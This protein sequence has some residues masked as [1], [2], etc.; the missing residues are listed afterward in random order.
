MDSSLGALETK[1]NLSTAPSLY[2][3]GHV[4][5]HVVHFTPEEKDVRFASVFAEWG[6]RIVPYLRRSDRGPRALRAA[7]GF[8]RVLCAM[9]TERVQLVRARLPYLGGLFGCLAGWLLGVPCVV[10]LG[11]DNRL[12]HDLS[13][14]YPFRNRPLS[15][16]I[17]VIV[18]RMAHTV[19]VPNSFTRDYVLGLIGA[20]AAARIRVIPWRIERTRSR[21]A[22]APPWLEP[23]I[24]IVL[25]VGFL[26][27]YKHT[28]VLYGVVERL[29][30]SDGVRAQFVFCGDGPL[31][32]LGE[33]TFTER[34]NVLFPGW[35]PRE[36]VETLLR[37]STLVL[38]P[39]S[40]FV[41]L[42]AASLG[43]AV[44]ASRLEWH[45]ELVRDGE[46]G[47]LVEAR[48]AAAW[49]DRIRRL[50]EDAPLRARLGEAL[51]LRFEADYAPERAEK[52][53]I[54]LYRELAGGST[55]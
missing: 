11:G 17:E 1:G 38:V 25:T 5:E 53:E 15:R 8:W 20:K 35:Q 6:I 34:R 52:A 24:P 42:E 49:T 26:N 16:A 19:I 43:R 54:D 18:L 3:P 51:R 10:S 13:G 39:M 23:G 41:L 36:T 31:R 47:F 44:V 32:D 28:D 14:E 55:A 12:A 50:L 40:G 27:P 21:P 29:T 7:V 33:R 4:A 37:H 48:D 30:R 2:N 9:R 45:S 46:S 22:E